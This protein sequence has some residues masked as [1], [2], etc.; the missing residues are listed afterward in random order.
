MRKPELLAP[1]G[2]LEKLVMAIRYGADAVYIGGREFGLR[3]AAGNFDLSEMNRG[4]K[5]AH[6]H[7]AK[8]YVTVNIFAHNRH[9]SSLPEYLQ[10]LAELGVDAIL[11]SDP[12]IFAAAREVVPGLPVHISTQANITNWASVKFWT[13]QGAERIVLARELSIEEIT[14][15]KAKTNIELEAFI[16]GA[17]CISYS[18]RCLLSNFMTGRSANLGECTQPC[19]WKY[20]IVEEKRPGQYFP[21]EEDSLGSY[22]FNSRD[23]CMIEHIPELVKAGIDSFKIEGRMKSVHYVATVIGAYREALD[24][25]YANPDTYTFDSRWMD[26]IHKVSHREYTTGFFF[27]KENMRGEKTDT[28]NY[29]RDYDFIGIVREYIAEEGKAV[30]EQRNRFEVGDLLEIT[31]PE[32]RVF[33]QK[34]DSL[35]D[36]EGNAIDIAP[37]PQQI[38]TMPVDNPVKPL[39]MLRREKSGKPD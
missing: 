11:V 7:G 5:F 20:S 6:D 13:D 32:T 35:S 21:V 9:L 12:G 25:Y 33:Y 10:K 15:I 19:R 8:V 36:A 38:V 27:G 30:I 16:H 2:D 23:L 39:D 31:G 22:V 17:M 18:G 37:H 14:E 1:A 3:A 4:I 34:V 28:S 29:R 26:E 24:T